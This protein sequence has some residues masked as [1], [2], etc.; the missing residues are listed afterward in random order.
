MPLVLCGQH[1]RLAVF[2]ERLPLLCFHDRFPWQE[3]RIE[4]AGRQARLLFADFSEQVVDLARQVLEIGLDAPSEQIAALLT[5]HQTLCAFILEQDGSGLAAVDVCRSIPVYYFEA[6]TASAG[7]GAIVVGNDAQT[8]LRAGE[9]A[10]GS[11]STAIDADSLLEMAMAGYCTAGQTIHTGLKQIPTGGWIRWNQDGGLERHYYYRFLAEQPPWSETDS[12]SAGGLITASQPLA[13][14]RIEELEALLDQATARVIAQAAGRP[15][16]VALSGGLDSRV[17]LAKLHEAGYDRLYAY[18]YG[19]P[20]NIDAQAAKEVAETLDVP[21]FWVPSDSKEGRAFFNGPERQT[22]WRFADGLSGIVLPHAEVF[23]LRQLMTRKLLPPET[24]FVN[25]Q[26]GDYLNGGHIPRV[27]RLPGHSRVSPATVK[28]AILDKHYSLWTSLATPAHGERMAARIEAVLGLAPGALAEETSCWS[29]E[30]AIRLYE[31]WELEARQALYVVNQQRAFEYVGASW[32]LP[33]WDPDLVRFF[34]RANL[35]ERLDQN[36]YKVCLQRWDYRG[37]FAGFRRAGSSWPQY[38]L[39]LKLAEY[40]VL[41]LLGRRGD[42]GFRAVMRY[43]GHYGFQLQEI[44]FPLFLRIRHDLRSIVSYH[45][46][47]W[48]RAQ[49]GDKASRIQFPL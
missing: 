5:Q 15:I 6:P 39:P 12:G 2:L 8:V 22:F 9:Q 11:G 27:L 10:N 23:P 14:A 48:V 43:I 45:A 49:G 3:K 38:R 4:Q 19:T 1:H 26:S 21:W 16:A 36:L 30:E 25:G 17:V 33:L 24:L 20:G 40:I 28:Q 7:T 44:P 37:L 41:R 29:R 31:R 42:T 47:A 35:E 18:S 13:L 34:G 32:A 46:A